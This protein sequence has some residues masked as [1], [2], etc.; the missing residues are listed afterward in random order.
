MSM[1]TFH[2]NLFP[3]FRSV[4]GGGCHEGAGCMAVASTRFK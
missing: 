4:G 2:V 3:V 1:G